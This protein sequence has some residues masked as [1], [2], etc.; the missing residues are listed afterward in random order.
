MRKLLSIICCAILA[1]ACS[2]SLISCD[3]DED[4]TGSTSYIYTY[5]SSS[6]SSNSSL[7][8]PSTAPGAPNIPTGEYMMQNRAN[9][10][11]SVNK[12]NKTCIQTKYANLAAYNRVLAGNAQTGDIVSTKTCDLVW[13]NYLLSW[14]PAYKILLEDG[15]SWR[16]VYQTSSTFKTIEKDNWLLP[17]DGK[18]VSEKAIKI[19]N[20][21]KYLYAVVSNSG[22]K[23][24]FY[25]GDT[26]TVTDPTTLTVY[27]TVDGCSGDDFYVNYIGS[28]KN[29][30]TIER[31]NRTI[32]GNSDVLFRVKKSNINDNSYVRLKAL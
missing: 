18:Y 26:G 22:A 15:T 1:F 13:Y 6:S 19:D 31:I 2:L 20:E 9:T 14:V 28:N 25:K 16:Y 17:D 3:T 21:E 32:S 5:T 12:D 7:Q 24:T 23:I 10:V 27:D 8:E 4:T 29:G 30:W 11:Y